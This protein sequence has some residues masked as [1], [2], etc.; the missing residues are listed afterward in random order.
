MSPTILEQRPDTAALK[1]NRRIGVAVSVACHLVLVLA[2]GR[3][4]AQPAEYGIEPGHGGIAVELV[5]ALP[6]STGSAPSVSV[7]EEPASSEDAVVSEAPA[8]Q[9]EPQPAAAQ[10]AV[11]SMNASPFVGDGS[12]PV[13]GQDATTFYSPGGGQTSARPNYLRNPVPPYPIEARRLGQTGLVVL[14]V[15]ID[16]TG[17]AQR[18]ELAQSSGFPILDGSALT[19]VRRWTFRPARTGGVPVE[20]VAEVPI[21]FTLASGR[22]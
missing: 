19:T 16:T 13:P 20:C 1:R 21:R 2:G 17:R 22:P 4:L 6:A 8:P 3:L 12:S 11:A 15:T 7:A 9:P 5:A 14:S 18:V 10:A